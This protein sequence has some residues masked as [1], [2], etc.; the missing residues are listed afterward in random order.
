MLPTNNKLWAISP[1]HIRCCRLHNID[2]HLDEWYFRWINLY[3][4]QFIRNFW[5]PHIRLWCLH[6]LHT[7]KYSEHH[8]NDLAYV[9]S[10][11]ST[12]TSGFDWIQ[13]M[14]CVL[15]WE[16]T[17]GWSRRT[18]VTLVSFRSRKA[19]DSSL[20][21]W[22]LWSRRADGSWF[23]WLSSWT[24]RIKHT[25]DYNGSSTAYA[26]TNEHMPKVCSLPIHSL[27]HSGNL[28]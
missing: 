20:S 27:Y 7:A 8:Q 18:H 24:L 3:A 14:C 25:S 12:M 1:K 28:Y 2:H 13:T 17:H 22:A 5:R 10:C 21:S 9:N 15:W 19:H 6:N 16:S 4:R 11:W 23:S 26:S